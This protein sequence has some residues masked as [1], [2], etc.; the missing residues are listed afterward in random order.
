MRIKF[1][2]INFCVLIQ[3]EFR[4]GLISWGFYFVANPSLD[5]CVL[6]SAHSTVILYCHTVDYGSCMPL[7]NLWYCEQSKL[8]K[9]RIC[10]N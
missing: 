8:F 7:F 4:G 9:L 6:S 10:K 3:A 2:G 1:R 5:F